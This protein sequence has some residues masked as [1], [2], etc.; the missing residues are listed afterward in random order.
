MRRLLP[1]LV[2]T[3][4]A[5]L[6]GCASAPCMPLA[7]DPAKHGSS[8]PLFLMTVQVK[9]DFKERW[10]GTLVNERLDVQGQ[11]RNARVYARTAA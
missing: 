1:L 6:A 3:I 2:L 11:L 8:K 5:L 10:Q 4:A 9:N 7:N